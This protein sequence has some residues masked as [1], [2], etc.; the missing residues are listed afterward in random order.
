MEKDTTKEIYVRTIEVQWH[1][2]APQDR[3]IAERHG[4]Q[5]HVEG[6]TSVDFHPTQDRLLTTGGD[7]CLIIWN[8]NAAHVSS[9][10]KSA[11]EDMTS[12]CVW[13]STMYCSEMPRCARWSPCGKMIAS[14]HSDTR[15]RLWW[16]VEKSDAANRSKDVAEPLEVWKDNRHL[17]GHLFEVMDIAFSP[18]SRH[19]V[20][21]GMQGC[22]IVHD[23]ESTVPIVSLDA[24]QKF[25][26]GVAW[27]PWN[28]NIATFGGTPSLMQHSVIPRKEHRRLQLVNQRKAVAPFFGETCSTSM[29]R[30]SWSPDGSMLAVPFGKVAGDNVTTGIDPDM[31]NCLYIFLR[32]QLER[33]AIKLTVRGA[34]E[35]RG[36]TWSPIFYEPYANDL[37]DLSNAKYAWGPAEYRMAMAAWT[38]D[39]VIVYT[40]D[41]GAR[42]SDFTDLHMHSITDVSWSNTGKFIF[43]SSLDGYVT[44]IMF[45]K[46][47]GT[48]VKLQDIANSPV[49]APL[50]K[51][52]SE[53]RRESEEY[54]A[55]RTA[56]VSK[57]TTPQVATPVVH[58]AKKK[59]KT[60]VPPAATNAAAAEKV[61]VQQEVGADEM[62][63]LL[64]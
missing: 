37:T 12:C 58:V 21:A 56:Q 3:E 31:K 60:E 17:T 59:R 1:F 49:S 32:N 38:E 54:E 40:T 11:V 23:L 47:L 26:Y 46:E 30:L 10:L 4:M 29:R 35:V 57:G 51:L 27:D 34:N 7:S 43:T 18:D 45:D 22:V 5:G 39:T 42:H 63:M 50:S 6:V 16:Q 24:H 48:P 64:D 52:F 19:L 14:A 13:V 8:F 53:L 44:V 20:S 41:Q 25:C 55:L 33:P 9:W 62:A 2:S 28:F 36:V 15:I 61:E